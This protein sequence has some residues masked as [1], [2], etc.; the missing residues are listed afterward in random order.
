M[1]QPPPLLG[2]APFAGVTFNSPVSFWL[3]TIAITSGVLLHLSDYFASA[4]MGY[5][6]AGMPMGTPMLVGMGLIVGGFALAARGLVSWRQLVGSPGPSQSAVNLRSMDGAKLSPAHWGLLFVLGVALIVDVMK[7]ATLGF[8]VPGLRDEYGLSTSRAALLPIMALTGTTLGSFLWGILADRVGRRATILLAS[9]MFIGTAICGF[10][11]SFGWNLF[12]C[13]VMGTSAGGM[14]PIV[15]ALMAESIPA[16]KRGWLVV[17]HGGLGTVGGYLVASG[18][19]AALEP[20]FAWRILWLPGLPTGLLL[21]VL[22]RWIPESPR[23]LLEHGRVDEAEAVLKRYGVLVEERPADLPAATAPSEQAGRHKGARLLRLFTEPYVGQTLA[24]AS[25]GMGWGLVNWGFLT[26]VPTILED[27]GVAVGSA[28]RILFLSALLAVPGTILVAYLYGMWSS[29]KSMILFAGLTALAL[30]GFAVLDPGSGGV[31]GPWLF[32]LM[33]LLLISSGG[34]ISMLSPYTAE[35]YP[36]PL[37][38]TGSGLAA[39]CSKLGGIVGPPVVA[40]VAAVTTGFGVVAT[41]VALPIMGS[42]AM[43]ALRGIETKDRA[44]EDVIA[45]ASGETLP[46]GE[47]P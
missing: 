47:A 7:P 26:F 6:M 24:I 23:F 14:L 20:T 42:A 18:L 5:H 43:I 1:P 4:S 3:G 46:A 8:V 34:V 17:L 41:L 13:F 16:K 19:A 10:M 28:S 25:Y 31:G 2:S 39:G 38:G 21:I 22:N 36:T 37:R 9:L 44:L 40:A 27:R 30:V 11:P 12:M 15:Y 45:S 33:A 29:R 35:V 32:P